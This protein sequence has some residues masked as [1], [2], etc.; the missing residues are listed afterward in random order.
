MGKY[1]LILYNNKELVYWRRWGGGAEGSK[2][3]E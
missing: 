3:G 2:D 1:N